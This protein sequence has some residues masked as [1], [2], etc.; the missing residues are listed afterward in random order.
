MKSSKDPIPTTGASEPEGAETPVGLP[1]LHSWK[2]VYVFV[3]VCFVV[4]VGLL[5]ALTV[6]YR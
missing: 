4:S 5:V 3:F 6:L 2:A 1:G